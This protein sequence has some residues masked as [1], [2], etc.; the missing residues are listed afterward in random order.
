MLQSVIASNI[1]PVG[2]SGAGHEEP[3][4]YPVL[5]SETSVLQQHDNALVAD[6]FD[7]ASDPPMAVAAFARDIMLA[8]ARDAGL[9]E[10]L[11]YQH[12]LYGSRSSRRR[13]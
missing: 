4:P 7:V 10:D 3:I 6:V 5:S 1:A 13:S 12:F 8:S 2:K 11:N 9:A